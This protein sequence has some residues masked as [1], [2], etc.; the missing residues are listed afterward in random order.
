MRSMSGGGL[1]DATIVPNA[2]SIRGVTPTRRW[3]ADL[4]LSGGGE[5]FGGPRE[6]GC[7]HLLYWRNRLFVSARNSN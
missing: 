7:H 4:P 3:H 6:Q 2:H 1:G 5:V